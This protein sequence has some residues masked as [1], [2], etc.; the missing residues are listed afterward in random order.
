[1]AL[2]IGLGA[3]LLCV[4]LFGSFALPTKTARTGDGVFFQFTMCCGIFFVG[5]ITHFIQ[6]SLG[7]NAGF[8]DGSPPACPQFV[9]LAALGGAIWCTSNMLLVPIV[10]C[11]GVGMCML[12]WG[13]L[14]MLAGWATGRFG[15]FGVDPEPITVPWLNSVGVVL[16]VGSL[17][18]LTAVQPEV[19]MQED[20][21]ARAAAS[22]FHT[23]PTPQLDSEPLL[24]DAIDDGAATKA[25]VGSLQAAT[26]TTGSGGDNDDWKWTDQ[27]TPL[28]KRIFG[29]AAC[30]IAGTLSGSTFTPIM[31]IVSAT[32]DASGANSMGPFPGASTQLLDHLYAHFTGIWLTS[33]GYLMLYI[34]ALRNRPRAVHPEVMLPGFV[35]G[36]VWGVAMVCWFIAN[37]QLEVVISFPMVTMGPGLVNLAYGCILF[38]EIR[39]RRNYG[40]LAAAIG[41][42]LAASVCIVLSKV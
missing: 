23:S 2:A 16:A 12:C 6:C 19:A 30:C 32:S 40:L 37:A 34:C 14:E 17:A 42:Y 27:L 29:V 11:I 7:S 9:P 8:T 31:Y 25:A 33:A 38:G 5:I 15:L 26:S 13:M 41:I 24:A 10:D 39:G 3:V 28:Q 36:C 20:A 18:V 22:V 1:M 35:S 21:D 4:I